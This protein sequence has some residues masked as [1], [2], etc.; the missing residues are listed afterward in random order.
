MS[1]TTQIDSTRAPKYPKNASTGT[2]KSRGSIDESDTIEDPT[3]KPATINATVRPVSYTH[4][5][6]PTILRV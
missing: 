1:I 4:L 2:P 5:A 3:N 6:L